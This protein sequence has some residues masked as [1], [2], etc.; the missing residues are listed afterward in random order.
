VTYLVGGPSFQRDVKT[1]DGSPFLDAV[2]IGLPADT[3]AWLHCALSAE[4][5]GKQKKKRD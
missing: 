2:H 3:R 4:E 5:Q 1:I